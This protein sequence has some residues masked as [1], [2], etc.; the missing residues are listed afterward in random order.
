MTQIRQLLERGDAIHFEKGLVQNAAEIILETRRGVC[1]SELRMEICR[2]L[3][4]NHEKQFE[5]DFA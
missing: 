5:E 4:P 1:R 3:E 2:E